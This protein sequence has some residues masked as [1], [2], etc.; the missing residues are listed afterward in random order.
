M[1]RS[2]Q[3]LKE[4]VGEAMVQHGHWLATVLRARGVEAGE[5]DELLQEVSVAACKA[6]D[7]LRD[8]EKIAPWLYRI[9]VVSALQYRRR[10]G[11]QR[12]KIEKYKAEYSEANRTEM[13]PL[14]WLLAKE[15]DQLVRQAIQSLPSRDAELMLL[16]YTED[17][18]YRQL[19]E[20]LGISESAVEARL[21]RARGK[22][23]RI[24]S[25]LEP[26]YLV[27]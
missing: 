3:K 14:S 6:V 18:T 11:R 7:Q 5:V 19:A 20:H 4:L 9:A 15:Q 25:L 16:K 2:Q 22:M 13:D 23:R 26:D 8:P 12:K 27:L 21:H 1:V 10:M 24:L 17:W